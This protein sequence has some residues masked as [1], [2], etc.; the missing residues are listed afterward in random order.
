MTRLKVLKSQL[1][2]AENR[3][4]PVGLVVV[5]EVV[6]LQAPG[7]V[8]EILVLVDDSGED[9]VAVGGVG[10]DQVVTFS[11]HSKFLFSSCYRHQIH[12]L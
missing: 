10:H 5:D 11:F 2:S 7:D 4:E 12:H 3:V 8:V 6:E 1:S 9:L